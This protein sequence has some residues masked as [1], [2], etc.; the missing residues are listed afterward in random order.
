MSSGKALT[1]VRML[2]TCRHLLSRVLTLHMLLQVCPDSVPRHSG[3]DR[4]ERLQQLHQARLRAQVAENAQPPRSLCPL[5]I[6]TQPE[7]AHQG[8][9]RGERLTP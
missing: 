4:D 7:P 6:R 5:A 2:P 8:N 1:G 3:Q 9:E